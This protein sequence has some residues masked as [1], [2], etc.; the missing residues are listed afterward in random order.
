[1]PTWRRTIPSCT[2]TP[3]EFG[4]PADLEQIRAT[5]QFQDFAA[6]I[7]FLYDGY[8]GTPGIGTGYGFPWVLF[9]LADHTVDEVKALAQA[10]IEA[11]LASALGSVTWKAPAGFKS[12]AGPVDFTFRSGLRVQPEMQDLMESLRAAGIDVYIVTASLKQLV[13]VF[14]GAGNFGYNVPADHVIGMEVELKDGMLQPAYKAGWVQPERAG[15]VE[16]IRR[17]LGRLG[18]PVF[19]AGDSDG[20]VEM[21]TRFSGMKLTLILNRVKGGD[22]GKLCR[23]AAEEMDR[24]APRYILQGRNENTGLFIPMSETIRFGESGAKLLP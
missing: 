18:E 16:A 23:Q 3:K 17:R 4:G 14:A 13:E 19:A 6:K 5:P 20:D 9:L 10:A 12:K 2:R 22:I 15:K 1:M 8:C 7:G 24:P 11:H 21:A